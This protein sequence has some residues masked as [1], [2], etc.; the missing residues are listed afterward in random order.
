MHAIL[1]DVDQPADVTVVI[2]THNRPT[3]VRHAVR[4]VLAQTYDAWRA[5]VVD[6]GSSAP[7]T[8]ELL[9]TDDPRVEILRHDPGR[10]VSEARN[11]AIARA[12]TPWIAFL[13]DDDLWAPTKLELQLGEAEQTGAAFLSCS[14]TYVRPDGSWVY[15]RP[16]EAT[17][18]LSATLLEYNA[19]GEPSTVLVSRDMLAR[20]GGFDPAF[21]MLADWDLWMRLSQLGPWHASPRTLCALLMHEGNM[22]VVARDT[23]ETELALLG[24]RHQDVI[25][26]VGHG[27]GSPF[28]DLWLAEKRRRADPGIGASLHYLRCLAAA[29]GPVGT[30]R[31]AARRAALAVR[32]R[33]A[34][35]WVTT[36]LVD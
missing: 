15:D 13:D 6:D 22:Q 14:A 23:A 2:P 31:R 11:A 33:R 28:I 17:P 8:H 26:R 10:G 36:L 18:D 19:V 32:P 25:A 21:S 16:A 1:R 24:T 4:S 3:D 9:G 35:D 5:I 12:T 27:F 7:V 30:A 29:R 34:P 20:A